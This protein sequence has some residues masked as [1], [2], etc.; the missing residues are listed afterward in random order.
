M[1][2][3]LPSRHQQ[4]DAINLQF[5][6]IAPIYGWVLSVRFYQGKVKYDLELTLADKSS[7]RI[8]NVDSDYVTP[9]S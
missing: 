2:I 8:Y 9:F 6:E 7:T 5:P 1:D 3:K 4:G